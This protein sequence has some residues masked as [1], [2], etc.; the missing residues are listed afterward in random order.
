MAALKHRLS[1][2]VNLLLEAEALTPDALRNAF[3][4]APLNRSL[5]SAT[6]ALNAFCQP[7]EALT[8]SARILARA[9]RKQTAD[10]FA[11]RSPR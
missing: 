6:I 9:F 10:A 3:A 7:E 8:S 2:N 11:Q 5:A 4:L 1:G